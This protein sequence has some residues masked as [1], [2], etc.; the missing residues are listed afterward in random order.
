MSLMRWQPFEELMSLR[1]AMDR[2][3][4]ESI[5][6]PRSLLAPAAQTFAVDIYET[7][8]DV[9]VKAS[10]PGV[11]PEDIEVSV[12][13]DT[14]TIKGEVKEEKD[15]K[16]ENYIRKERRYGS[17]CRSFTLPVSVDADKATAEFENGVLTLT[18][19]KAEEVKPKTIAIKA[20][21]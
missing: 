10:L 13:G 15:I 1:E 6:W 12:V 16:E 7:K 17:F 20:K 3:F 8:D 2:L 5:V 4:E 14:L 19:P 21:K 11:K 18:L 9:V